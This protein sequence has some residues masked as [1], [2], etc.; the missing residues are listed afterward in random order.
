MEK[1]LVKTAF[2]L[3]Y[4]QGLKVQGM[5]KEAGIPLSFLKP[6]ANFGSKLLGSALSTRVGQRVAPVVQSAY[7][8][9]MLGIQRYLQLMRGGNNEVVGKYRRV[10][11]LLQAM[12]SRG[13]KN[14]DAAMMGAA[15]GGEQ[16]L[17]DLVHMKPREL[18]K[19]YFPGKGALE[20]T[21]RIYNPPSTNLDE[22]G[23]W[24]VHTLPNRQMRVA[25][26]GS[27]GKHDF[28]NIGDIGAVRNELGKVLKTRL[29]TA[30]GVAGGL[31]GANAARNDDSSP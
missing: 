7:G 10:Q 17:Y 18:I 13:L 6:V 28:Y 3:G 5:D 21:T 19:T 4:L 29:I 16:L 30:G 8:R 11:R 15:T 26:N 27:P 20:R 24:A 31:A 14:R 9:V 23:S 2:Q 25:F 12:R 22:L 1:E